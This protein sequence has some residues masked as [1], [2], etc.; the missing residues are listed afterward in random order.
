MALERDSL[1]ARGDE[2]RALLE[3]EATEDLA[4]SARTRLLAQALA[5]LDTALPS[6][7]ATFVRQRASAL[8]DDHERLRSAD[9]RRSSG[10]G[11]SRVIVEPVLPPDV[12]GLYVLVPQS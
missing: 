1:V 4:E 3:A 5:R 12:I 9:G 2:A 10:A 8:A 11:G 6:A 7:I